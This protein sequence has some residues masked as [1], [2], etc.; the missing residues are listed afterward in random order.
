MIE[1]R[2]LLPE[3]DRV[4][5]LW[6]Q[7]N[8]CACCRDSEEAR[9]SSIRYKL[10]L[11]ASRWEEEYVRCRSCGFCW[12]PSHALDLA[13]RGWMGVTLPDPDPELAVVIVAFLCPACSRLPTPAAAPRIAELILRRSRGPIQ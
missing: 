5:E 6:R 2:A 1:L 13:L 12:T 10:G 4:D 9:R 8:F 7:R 3:I 11:A